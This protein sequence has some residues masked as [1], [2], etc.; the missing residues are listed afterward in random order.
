MEDLLCYVTK[1]WYRK[2]KNSLTFLQSTTQQL[3]VDVREFEKMRYK[4]LK[5]II[6][7]QYV[8]GLIT[9]RYLIYLY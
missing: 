5:N 9:H 7:I 1:V 4:M 8:L 2:G 3:R 6:D